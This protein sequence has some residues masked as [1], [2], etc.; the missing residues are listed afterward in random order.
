MFVSITQTKYTEMEISQTWIT[1][2]LAINLLSTAKQ[3]DNTFDSLIALSICLVVCA[4][5]FEPKSLCLSVGQV[6]AGSEKMK[7]KCDM[8]VKKSKSKLT[9]ELQ[10]AWLD[11]RSQDIV[12]P[13]N[14]LSTRL[15]NGQG[16]EK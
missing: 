6:M 14:Y 15:S 5:L 13:M 3:R 12:L 7:Q 16:H 11:G 1:S 2:K 9:F 8:K 10:N 4:P